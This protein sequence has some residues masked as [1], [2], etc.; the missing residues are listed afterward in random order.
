MDVAEDLIWHTQV[1]LKVSIFAWLFCA[2]GYKPKQTWFL[3]ASYH[4]KLIAACL[5]AERSNWPNIYSS[6]AALLVLCVLWFALG[7]TFLRW[8]LILFQ[9]TLS[10]LPTQRVVFVRAN[11]FCS[12]SGLPAFGLRGVREITDYSEVHQI[13]YNNYWT[14]SRLSPLGRCM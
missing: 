7:L 8:T 1:P 10:S 14:R 13:P 9:I 3:E 6:L 2:T 12:S 5:D 11:P 4:Q